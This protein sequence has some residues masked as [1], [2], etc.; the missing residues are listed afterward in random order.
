MTAYSGRHRAS[1]PSR[2]GRS[3]AALAF[4]SAALARYTVDGVLDP[5]FGTNGVVVRECGTGTAAALALTSDGRMVIAGSTG[6]CDSDPTRHDFAVARLQRDGTP[7]PTFNGGRPMTA[8]PGARSE[9]HD[10]GANAV[11][12]QPDGKIVV[13]GSSG[14]GT[15]PP[16][17]FRI[18]ES[19]RLKPP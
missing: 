11:A 17:A 16:H 5:L 10:A 6:H 1:H 4:D 13:A 7:D 12:L 18:V 2:L 8:T 19:R 14:N 15:A 3:L 9:P